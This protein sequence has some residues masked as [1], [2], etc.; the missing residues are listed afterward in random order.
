MRLKLPIDECLSCRKRVR[1]A[2]ATE[3]HSLRH[4]LV[5]VALYEQER[6]NE[7]ML[8][9]TEKVN[10]C[11]AKLLSKAIDIR[12]S[13][14]N[15]DSER[16]GKY[17]L[18]TALVKAAEKIFQFV[19]YT[20]HSFQVWHDDRM[21][22][23]APEGAPALL[24]DLKTVTGSE[25]FAKVADIAMSNARDELMLLAHTGESRDPVLHLRMTPET[26]VL[27]TLILLGAHHDRPLLQDFGILELYR[28]QLVRL[29]R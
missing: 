11:A 8:R 10:N 12:T 9:F 26:T 1:Y 22:P 20:A 13:V 25:Y 23:I 24:A 3:R 4:W 29:V 19:Y 2:D 28:E 18:P 27:A 16:D 5:P 21:I 6:D 15:K 17:L 14:A 7:E